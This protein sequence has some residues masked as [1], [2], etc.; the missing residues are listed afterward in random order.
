VRV[1]VPV[2]VAFPAVLLSHHRP[3]PPGDSAE[4]KKE[5]LLT[6]LGPSTGVIPN[7]DYPGLQF[8]QIEATAE[9][10]RPVLGKKHRQF[11]AH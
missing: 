4:V 5:L 3:L 1:P 2:P 7:V 9:R 11:V 6:Q 10:F 8:E